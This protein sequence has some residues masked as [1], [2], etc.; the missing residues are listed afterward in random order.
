MST[1]PPTPP[2]AHHAPTPPPSRTRL[3]RTCAVLTPFSPLPSRVSLSPPHPQ[4]F[5]LP[6][7][8]LIALC[9]RPAPIVA[10][11]STKSA[12][13]VHELHGHTAEVL[14]V[15]HLPALG[16]VVTSGA[17]LALCWWEVRAQR[18]PG[19]RLRG[20]CEEI[21]RRLRGD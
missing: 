6:Q 17:D 12:T 21:E 2:H 4:I 9:E 16:C 7:L 8:E 11:Y 19:R 15:A 10:I 13:C 18:P 20:D 14:A 1:T 5:Y 3:L